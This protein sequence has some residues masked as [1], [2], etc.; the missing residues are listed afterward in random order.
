MKKLF[1]FL[2]L[3]ITFGVSAQ[4][5]WGNVDKNKV[6]M[7]EIAPVWPG[8]ENKGNDCFDQKLQEHIQKNFKYPANAWKNNVQERIV[9]TF[10]V[11][12]N[13]LPVIKEV[14]GKNQELIDE[15]KRI[16]MAMPKVKPG[17][18]AGKPTEIQYTVP[19]NFKTGK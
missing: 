12:K 19:F 15:A 18:L 7:K 10:V 6:T 11:D 14:E 16:I 1:L 17:M 2:A 13:G 5:K 3:I 4:E 9:I 8:C